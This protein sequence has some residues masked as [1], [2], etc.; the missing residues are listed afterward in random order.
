MVDTIT[1]GGKL[2]APTPQRVMWAL[3]AGSIASALLYGGGNQALNA[4]QAGT[5]A[6]GIPFTLVIILI[7]FCLYKAFL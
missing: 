3:A 1:A 4:L 7:C 2:D 6:T 5:I